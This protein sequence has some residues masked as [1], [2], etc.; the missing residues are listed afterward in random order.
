MTD[1]DD[2]GNGSH[3]K[4]G[5]KD[6]ASEIKRLLASLERAESNEEAAAEALEDAKK[7]KYL[8]CE[9]IHTLSNGEMFQWKG[10][11]TFV[12]TRTNKTTKETTY[13]MRAEKERP[14]NI[15]SFD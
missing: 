5:V 12:A 1:K 14:S 8:I 10:K 15:V 2:N 3:V 6:N 11:N 13:Y 7:A 4:V 9:Q